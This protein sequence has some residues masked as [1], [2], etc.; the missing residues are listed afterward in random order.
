MVKTKIQ[1]AFGAISYIGNSPKNFLTFSFDHFSM[2]ICTF[3]EV[4]GEKLVGG[5][6]APPI[7]SRVK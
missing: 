6:F 4:T 5:P 7:L 1:K 3:V 2:Y